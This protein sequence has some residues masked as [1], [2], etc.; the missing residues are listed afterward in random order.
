[1]TLIEIVMLVGGGLLVL[2]GLI[3][4]ANLPK[5]FL[6]A[7]N[8]DR[9]A[10]HTTGRVIELIEEPASGPDTNPTW[11]PVV[12][13]EDR[14]GREHTFRARYGTF[15][16]RWAVG[17]AIPVAHPPSRPEQARI[18]NR[19]MAYQSVLVALVIGIVFLAF[20]SVLVQLALFYD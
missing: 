16:S 7:R 15:H 4:I 2:L 11:H 5:V 12:K 3:A 13:F 20:G 6:E 9:K 19:F 8:D 1:M 14:D 18:G 10:T 17:D